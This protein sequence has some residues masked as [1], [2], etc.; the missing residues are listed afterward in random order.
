MKDFFLICRNVTYELGGAEGHRT[1]AGSIPGQSVRDWWRT[2]WRG[3]KFCPTLLPIFPASTIPQTLHFHITFIYSRCLIILSIHSVAQY[4]TRKW[5]DCTVW[6]TEI[7]TA[8]SLRIRVFGDVT[9]CHGVK[10]LLT[11]RMFVISSS[12]RVSI[13]KSNMRATGED[14]IPRPCTATSKNTSV[15]V[16]R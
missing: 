13:T 9:P 4:N 10:S 14:L 12:W 15:A 11:F 7:L 1:D 6:G 2:K 8:L 3:Y 5:R 16:V